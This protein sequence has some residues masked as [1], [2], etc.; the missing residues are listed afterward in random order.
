[1]NVLKSSEVEAAL[2]AGR[3]VV[4]LES[5][6]ISHGLP[7]PQNLQL[8][9]ELENI[10]RAAGAVPATIA[11]INGELR[12]GLS[13]AEIVLLADGKIPVRKMS[14]RDFGSVIA[15]KEMGA[16]TV[17]ATMI[18]AQ[19][20]GIRVFATGG[21]G[22]VHRGQAGD[23]SADLVELSQTPVAVVC[24]GVKAILDLP[25]TLEWLETFGVPVVG[26]DTTE[27]PAFYTRSSGLPLVDHVENAAQVA[28][29]LHTHWGLGFP[30]G[31]L[32]TV[33]I[34]PE[35]ALNGDEINPKIEQAVQEAEQQ[36]ITGKDITPFLLGRLAEITEGQSMQANLA[37]LR[38]N[39]RVAA[40][41]AIEL[42]KLNSPA[43]HPQ[44]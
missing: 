16:T 18:I 26:Y 29:L 31:A 11:V 5:T 39:A 14:R 2:K 13:D 19:W 23:V 6:V 27:F 28:T 25:R 17:A 15:K 1:M 8:A 44:L 41:I 32:I 12:A 24:A 38:N 20:A 9:Q 7:Y 4:A 36:H 22:G 21:V 40:E 33:P 10:I 34:P 43:A 37:L 3:P 42:Q 30:Q 35:S